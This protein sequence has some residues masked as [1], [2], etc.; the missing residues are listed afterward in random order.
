MVPA[1][2]T[3]QLAAEKSVAHDATY[4]NQL[5]HAAG[6]SCIEQLLK[7]VPYGPEGPAAHGTAIGCTAG[8]LTLGLR[9]RT[10]IA[11]FTIA[12]E[13]TAPFDV[14][15]SFPGHRIEMHAC[16]KGKSQGDTDAV[17]KLSGTDVTGPADTGNRKALLVG[18]SMQ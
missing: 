10:G 6:K 16:G 11:D 13:D 9:F 18:N 2:I 17:N 8:Y 15:G 1:R 5:V 7:A 4:G 14:H 12:A 3:Q